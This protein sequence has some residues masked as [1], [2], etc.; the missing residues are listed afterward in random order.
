MT[1]STKKPRCDATLKTLT[2]KEQCE[3]FEESRTKSIKE[4][5]GWLAS[6]KKMEVS[7]STI[8]RFLG[9]F[10]GNRQ[11][12]KN[13]G[14]LEALKERGKTP[15]EFL[16]ETEVGN[17]DTKVQLKAESLALQRER[18]KLDRDKFERTHIE[19]IARI[20]N[21]PRVREIAKD[22]KKSYT[23]RLTE[24]RTIMFGDQ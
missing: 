19:T 11:A 17:F 1:R 13:E 7:E 8:S 18:L 5:Q 14:I 15:E 4:I 21:N 24:I 2:G 10:R 20:C 22:N 23:E 12:D 6:E 16:A 9:W 3:L